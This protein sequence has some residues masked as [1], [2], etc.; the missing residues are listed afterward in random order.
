MKRA[1]SRL[2][3]NRKL[4]IT[5]VVLFSIAVG[6]SSAALVIH[7]NSTAKNSG[8]TNPASDNTSS[9]PSLAKTPNTAPSTS[10]SP[11]ESSS[12]STNSNSNK[13]LQTENQAIELQAQANQEHNC[14]EFIDKPYY[15]S[16]K[17][18]QDNAYNYT[19]S[20]SNAILADNTL[21]IS[22]K[23]TQL[24]K[25]HADY[26]TTVDNAYAAYTKGVTG[27]GCQP[28]LTT[29]PSHWSGT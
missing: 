24:D 3:R 13:S 28:S 9:N 17:L 4:Q 18:T 22:E 26:N 20:Q 15:S 16:F 7:N 19:V 25:L 8:L 5:A 27:A 11:K 14:A 23:N 6:A 29:P 12:S 2:L 1:V 10:S 21:S